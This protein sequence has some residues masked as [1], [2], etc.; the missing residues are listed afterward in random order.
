MSEKVWDII[1]FYKWVHTSENIDCC[2]VGHTKDMVSRKREHKTAYCNP[3]NKNY[4]RK[5][6]EIMRQH[7][8]FANWKMV[9]IGCRENITK[10]DAVKIE[11]EYRVA[12]KADMNMIKCY[13][14]PE[15]KKEDKKEYMKNY[16]K[17]RDKEKLKEYYI[18]NKE[19]I[20]EYQK[21][22]K[23]DNKDKLKEYFKLREANRGYR[24]RR[25][26]NK[27][28][29]ILKKSKPVQEEILTKEEILTE[30]EI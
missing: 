26:Y 4:N 10:R 2:Y 6:Y 9:E 7:G 11:E 19:K 23:I 14:S 25:E 16:N 17:Q 8:G 20:L 27:Q 12:L 28:R 30:E 1:Y 22:Y 21:Q 24:D 5:I 15:D 29:Y 13:A 3:N 18:E